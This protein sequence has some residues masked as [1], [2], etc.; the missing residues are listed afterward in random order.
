MLDAS[1]LNLPTPLIM[2]VLLIEDS[3]LIRDT[4]ISM[5]SNK[6]NL[7]IKAFADT[8]KSAITLRP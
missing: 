1:I 5:L 2:R 8:E 6:Q 4:L 7:V 3:K